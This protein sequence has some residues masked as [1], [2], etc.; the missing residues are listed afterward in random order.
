MVQANELAELTKL[1]N[2][3]RTIKNFDVYTDV[4]LRHFKYIGCLMAD[5][6]GPDGETG[7]LYRSAE[8]NIEDVKANDMYSSFELAHDAF[9]HGFYKLL[10]DE[11]YKISDSISKVYK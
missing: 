4:N 10:K 1:E 11:G 3:K 8:M 5:F 7:T 9:R 6:E 2:G